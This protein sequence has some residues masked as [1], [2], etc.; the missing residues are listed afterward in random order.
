[1]NRAIFIIMIPAV[2]V[3]V[4]YIV[5]LRSMGIAPG[6]SRLIIAIGLF[7]AAIF[8]FSRR[9]ARKADSRRT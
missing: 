1:M 7:F 9:A 6:Y 5:V 8:W 2:L 4:G 3:M